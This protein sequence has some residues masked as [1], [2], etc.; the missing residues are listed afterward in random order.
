VPA[1]SIPGGLDQDGLPIGVQLTAPVLGEPTLLRA[2]HAL[3]SDLGLQLRP[4]V[5]AG[6]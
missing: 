5:L 3:E 2:A 1:I 4:P 6:L